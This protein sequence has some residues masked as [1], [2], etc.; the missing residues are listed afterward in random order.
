MLFDWDA[1]NWPKCGKHGLS[2]LEIEE[3]FRNDPTIFSDPDDHSKDEQRL[4]AIGRSE[5]GRFVFVVFT[6][7]QI[8]EIACIRPVSARYMHQKEIDR[9]VHTQR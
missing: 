7:R 9:Y 1:G 8:G 6:M 2:Q 5:K 3:V 4:K